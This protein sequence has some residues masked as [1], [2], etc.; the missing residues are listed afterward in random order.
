MKPPRVYLSGGM[1]N[2]PNFN[3]DLFDLVQHDLEAQG[4]EVDSPA[5]HDRAEIRRLVSATARAED[6][7]GYAEG[8]VKRY[9]AAIGTETEIMF[10]WDFARIA[11]DDGIVMLPGWEKSTGARHERYVAEALGKP[12]YLAVLDTD[13]DAYWYYRLELDDEQQRLVPLLA[14]AWGGVLALRPPA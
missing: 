2:I 6:M 3:F 7:D 12:V 11:A 8:D 5:E 10:V 1:T 13:D 14:W 4:I 9:M